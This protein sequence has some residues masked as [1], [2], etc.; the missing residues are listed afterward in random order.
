MPS[1]DP[2]YLLFAAFVA[3]LLPFIPGG[4]PR[5]AALVLLSL[6]FYA[7]FN[8]WYLLI[9]TFVT[10]S[11]FGLAL[12]F[13]ASA[14]RLRKPIFVL[15]IIIALL[16]LL[17]FKYLG[18]MLDER[19][20]TLIWWLSLL[21]TALPVGL[22]FYTFQAVGY[23]I[24]V[25]VGN[26]AAE[27]DAI[28]FSAFMSFFPQLLAGPIERAPHLLPQLSQL[29]QF[30]YTRAVAGVRAILIGLFLKI[31]VADSLS[32]LVDSV[33]SDPRRFSS[34]DLALATIYFSFEVYADFAGYSLIAI[35]SARLLG[36]ELLQNFTQPFLSQSLPE[37]WRTW[38]ITLSSWFRDYVFTPL[39]FQWRRRGKAG[40]ALA[41]II[42]FTIVGIWHGSGWK[43]AIFGLMH[44]LLVSYSTL[45]FRARDRAWRKS[46]I[47]MSMV[48]VWRAVATFFAVTLTFVLFR[49]DDTA[50]AAWIY[51]QLFTGPIRGISLPVLWPSALIAIVIAGDLVARHRE[52]LLNEISP[53]MRWTVYHAATLTVLSAMLLHFIQG[54][55]HV[56]QF[57]YYKF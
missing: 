43:Y 55:Q 12:V 1:S 27:R 35:G 26:L 46:G 9:L 20:S 4:R 49:A 6:L 7:S 30:E 36:I 19:L 13:S 14:E 57:I 45:T 25:Y 23:L 53:L 15:S 24:D 17:S 18:G 51:R 52:K 32:P 29:G 41:L 38:H 56:R 47:P 48:A 44:G 50:T 37:Y 39:Q 16:P 8:P 3:L 40:L 42:T 10:L 28:R 2:R 54:A 5:L 31:V 11:T 33:Y 22:S 21:N 34:P